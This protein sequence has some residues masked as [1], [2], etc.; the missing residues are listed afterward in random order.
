MKVPKL[1]DISAN[2]TAEEKKNDVLKINSTQDYINSFS[3]KGQ[4][5][6]LG[7]RVP[8]VTYYK[9]LKICQKE[10]LSLTS[11]LIFL[12]NQEIAKDENK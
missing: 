5:K 7:I 10:G 12:I 2:Q 8:E 6:R 1:K 11:K 3:S 4:L 9:F